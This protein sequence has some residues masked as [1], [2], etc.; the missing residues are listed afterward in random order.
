MDK[1]N[2]CVFFNKKADNKSINSAFNIL[3]ALNS[4]KYNRIPI[5]I[6]DDGKW[7]LYDGPIYDILDN[8]IEKL[9][10]STV[11]SPCSSHNGLIRI[12]KDKNRIIPID[13]AISV[14]FDLDKEIMIRGMLE[15]SN[16][17]FIGQKAVDFIKT[18]DN[19]IKYLL[20]NKNNIN[21]LNYLIFNKEEKENIFEIVKKEMKFPVLVCKNNNFENIEYECN[22]KSELITAIDN[23]LKM[24][25]V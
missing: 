2:I 14:L 15:N 21:T 10:V 12:V 20:A 5:Y 8:N 9:G 24:K 1:V 23:I 3:T 19:E 22:K 4:D 25:I 13:M 17:K 16:I 18:N 7:F 11:L 6:D